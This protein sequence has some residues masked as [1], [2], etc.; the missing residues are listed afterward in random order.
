MALIMHRFDTDQTKEG[1]AIRMM[2]WPAWEVSMWPEALLIP[3]LLE[4]IDPSYRSS[5]VEDGPTFATGLFDID[6]HANFNTCDNLAD[7]TPD[8]V[9]AFDYDLETI[10]GNVAGWGVNDYADMEVFLTTSA[11]SFT[12]NIV[13]NTVDTL[14]VS[15]DLTVGAH[16]IAATDPFNILSG[17]DEFQVVLQTLAGGDAAVPAD[18]ANQFFD[19]YSGEAYRDYS[20]CDAPTTPCDT[21]LLE[22]TDAAWD[23]DEFAYVQGAPVYQVE[24][25]DGTGVGQVSNIVSNTSTVLTLADA[26]NPDIGTDSLYVISLYEPLVGMKTDV[27]FDADSYN[28]IGNITSMDDRDGSPSDLVKC[29][30]FNAVLLGIDLAGVWSGNAG[31]QGGISIERGFR[32]AGA[33][34]ADA[35]QCDYDYADFGGVGD[36]ITMPMV[37]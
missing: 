9:S 11:G 37:P 24:I 13:S 27:D 8:T 28:I 23:P 15:E 7:D 17:D 26:F 18:L 22:D 6:S 35:A 34:C 21:T 4:N 36:G 31:A 33:L 12:L 19:Y 5:D 3:D 29:E 14:T 20:T 2:M 32:V 30:F 25:L 1:G 10:T 16:A